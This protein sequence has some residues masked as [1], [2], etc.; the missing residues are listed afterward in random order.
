MDENDEN[1]AESTRHRVVIVNSRRSLHGAA[2]AALVAAT[3]MEVVADRKVFLVG[4]VGGFG[5]NPSQL[6]VC[7]PALLDEKHTFKRQGGR[8]YGSP[9]RRKRSSRRH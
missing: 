6:K 4:G 7:E 9:F 3:G 5:F 2:M 1:K 8:D